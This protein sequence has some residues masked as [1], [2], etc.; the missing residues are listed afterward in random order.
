MDQR[1]DP[2]VVERLIHAYRALDRAHANH[3]AN[4]RVFHHEHVVAL[5]RRDLFREGGTGD[6]HPLA[7][8]L[9][10]RLEGR[11]AGPDL[12]GQRHQPVQILFPDCAYD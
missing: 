9:A 5:R 3:L 6:F 12:L 1:S 2:V 7:E 4:G 8:R 11:H 10:V